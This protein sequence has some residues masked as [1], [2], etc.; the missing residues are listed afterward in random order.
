MTYSILGRDLTTGE[1]GGAVQSAWYSSVGV[2]WVEAGVGAVASQAMGER[3]FGHLGL[4]M[5]AAGATAAQSTAAILAGDDLRGV[6]QL[7]MMDLAST[8]A[9]FTGSDCV[10]DA[11]HQA[12]HDCVAQAN[13]MANP[14]VPQAM[15]TAFED[16]PGD[17]TDRLLA[18]LDAAQATGGDFRGMQSAGLIVRHGLRGTPA[19]RTAIVNVRVD[20]DPAPLVELRRLARLSRTYRTTNT[21]LELL[22]AGDTDRAVQAARDVC[23]RVPGDGNSRLRL[24]LV[25]AAS[26][27]PEGTEIL[28]ELARD[29]EKWLAYGRAVCLHYQIDPPPILGALE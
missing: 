3:T 4:Q 16:T 24:G 1:I 19:W 2:L 15:A 8:P 6:R 29:S 22:A 9:A 20:D 25:L 27:D 18:A 21:S 28:G 13:M 14:G 17:L 5:M 11:G 12:G 7:G 10:P 23:S 26:G